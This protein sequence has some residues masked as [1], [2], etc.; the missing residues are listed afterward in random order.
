MRS[1]LI[2]PDRSLKI[3]AASRG[4]SV[5]ASLLAAWPL[6]LAYAA[7]DDGLYISDEEVD[8]LPQDTPEE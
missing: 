2:R 5:R 8:D 3:T 7:S 1:S 6:T 4:W